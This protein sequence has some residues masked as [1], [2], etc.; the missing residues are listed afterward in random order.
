ML[1][2]FL[3]WRRR[4]KPE[5]IQGATL[6]ETLHLTLGALHELNQKS[7][8]PSLARTVKLTLSTSSLKELGTLLVEASH[9]VN[10]QA[11]LPAHIKHRASRLQVMSLEAYITEADELVHPVDWLEAQQHYIQKLLTAIQTLDPAEAEYYQRK[12][13]FIIEDLATLAKASQA[14]LR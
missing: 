6:Y 2:S 1:S 9:C 12:C 4:K 14:C 11:Y 7:F 13:N 3:P 5:P 10:T 8:S